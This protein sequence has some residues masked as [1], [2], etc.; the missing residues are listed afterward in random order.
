MQ[1]ILILA[2]GRAGRRPEAALAA[3]YLA[4]LPLPARL[5]EFEER[6]PLPVA[7][8]RRREGEKLLAALPA[9]ASLIALDEAGKLFDSADFARKLEAL[10][11][12]GRTLAFAI[13]GADGHDAALLARADLTLSL[14]PMTWPHM[15]VRVMLAEQLFRGFSIL[16]N[17]PYHRA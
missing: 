13:G 12:S 2:I 17:H 4:R 3:D 10:R 1:E 14:S 7:E 5:L 9:S 6:R 8:R 11:D 15:L 16:A